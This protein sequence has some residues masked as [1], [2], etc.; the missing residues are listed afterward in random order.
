MTYDCSYD[1]QDDLM[2]KDDL[3]A[4]GS[5]VLLSGLTQPSSRAMATEVSQLK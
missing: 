4:I 2:S 1:L 3:I 5:S